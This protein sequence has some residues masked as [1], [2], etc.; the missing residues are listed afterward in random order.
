[1]EQDTKN[2]IQIFNPDQVEGKTVEWLNVGFYDCT[3]HFTDNTFIVIS[4]YALDGWHGDAAVEILPEE[5]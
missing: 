1:M 2:K 5:K 3:I 4:T